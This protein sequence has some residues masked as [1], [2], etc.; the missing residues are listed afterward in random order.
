MKFISKMPRRNMAGEDE[1]EGDDVNIIV[2]KNSVYFYEDISV[3]S[4]RK[5]CQHIC[6]LEINLLKIQTDYRLDN[7]PK[8]YLH[9]QSSGG[10]AYAGLSGMNTIQ[11]CRVPVIT[12][13]DGFVASAATFL[14]LGGTERW[15]QKHANLLIHQIRTEFWGRFDELKDEM[16]N[17]EHLM[18]MIKT[19]YKKNSTMPKKT[20]NGI[21]KKEICMN[22]DECLNYGL[23]HNII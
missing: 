4:I 16:S 7:P 9:I 10:D 1:E 19:I 15:M 18:K 6:E 13:V 17:S 11:N 5:L 2:V 14:L 12:I 22:A 8:I 20:L 3:A 23:I 21:I